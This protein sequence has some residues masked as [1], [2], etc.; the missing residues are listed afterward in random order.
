VP[1]IGP[2][3]PRRYQTPISPALRRLHGGVV[4][5]PVDLPPAE[6]APPSPLGPQ[7]EGGVPIELPGMFAPAYGSLPQDYFGDAN[8]APGA[9]ATL[10]SF[11]VPEGFRCRM[12]GIGFGADDETALTFLTWRIEVDSTRSDPY[13]NVP[14]AVGSITQ[15]STIIFTAAGGAMV[16]VIAAAAAT[17]GLTYRYIARTKG[18]FFTEQLRRGA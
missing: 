13:V 10:I 17:A 14:A 8:I 4:E 5:V 7:P 2:Q 3:D 1:R 9:E 16:A 12:D 18:W 15:L 11:I 6:I